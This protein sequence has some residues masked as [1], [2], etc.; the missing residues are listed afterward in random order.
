MPIVID[1]QRRLAR[2]ETVTGLRP[3]ANADAIELVGVGGWNVVCKIGDF[4]VGDTV[5][6]FEVDTA[7]PV[8]DD[9]YAF[10]APRGVKT[11]DGREYHVLK[12]ARLRGEYSQGLILPVDQ[13]TDD[14]ARLESPVAGANMTHVLGLG[15]WEPPLPTG[16]GDARGVF[17]TAY[18]R[19]TDSDRVQ[20]LVASYPLLRSLRWMA[21]EKIDGTSCTMLRTN[22]GEL[23]VMGR[24]WDIADGDNLYWNVARRYSD[25]VD[26]ITPGSAV[27][28]EIAG[29]GVNGNRLGL[30]EVRP[31]V[32]DVIRDRKPI[33]RSEWPDVLTTYAAPV[34]DMELPESA[35]E[36]IEMVDGMH[37]VVSPSRLAEGVVFHTD[38]G[39]GIDFL[40]GRSTFKVISNK[41]LLKTKD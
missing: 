22:D 11:V 37:S 14:I 18:A 36:L 2:L 38:D 39:S 6:Y 28:L 25:I 31:F 15:K 32:F 30:S 21:T 26:T 19:K 7:L 20:N 13:F 1:D 5:V 12:T 33:A 9:R 8:D 34:I 4:R 3:I 23:H 10:L 35:G 27:Q 41:Y 17:L 16:T 24:N 40:D 29:P